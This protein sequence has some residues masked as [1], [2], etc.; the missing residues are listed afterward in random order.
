IVQET[1]KLE[2]ALAKEARADDNLVSRAEKTLK[3]SQKDLSKAE[4]ALARSRHADS[5][6]GHAA[7][8]EH[9]TAKKL[10]DA[11]HAHDIAIANHSRAEQDLGI[12]Q[13]NVTETQRHVDAHQTALGEA[14]RAK[15]AHE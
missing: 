12:R 14:Q 7:K 5:A 3:G 1:K 2:S 11:K 13:R 15:D 8:V 9:K 4:K 10:N 6:L